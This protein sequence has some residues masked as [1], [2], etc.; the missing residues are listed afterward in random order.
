MSPV[1]RPPTTRRSSSTPATAASPTS[2]SSRSSP[3]RRPSRNVPNRPRAGVSLSRDA[4]VR[5]SA[6]GGPVLDQP[7]TGD[8]P[9]GL[10]HEL[11]DAVPVR[12]VVEPHPDPPADADVGRPEELPGLVLDEVALHT[13]VRRRPEG[14]PVVVVVVGE[15]DEHPLAG[16]EPAGFAVARPLLRLREGHAQGPDALDQMVRA[17]V[18][19]HHGQPCAPRPAE[20]PL[21]W[22][23]SA[24]NP[25][26]GHYGTR[27]QTA[28]LRGSRRPRTPPGSWRCRPPWYPSRGP[29]TARARPRAP[30]PRAGRAPCPR[31]PRRSPRAP[32]R[33]RAAGHRPRRRRRAQARTTG[34]GRR[35]SR[36]RRGGRGYR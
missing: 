1:A 13:V 20:S 2:C 18:H 23:P 22:H 24:R 8:A 36:R 5:A 6:P 28:G 21:Q 26:T 35:R 27:E 17:P 9:P 11:F 15:H 33:G 29:P 31:P 3:G 19:R 32:H 12:V 30:A 34:R 16:D 4:L 25:L 14:H 10:F 7:R